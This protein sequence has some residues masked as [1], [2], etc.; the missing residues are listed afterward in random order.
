MNKSHGSDSLGGG[1]RI[2][3]EKKAQD[4]ISR[5]F[6]IFISWPGW[7]LHKCTYFI[8][9]PLGIYFPRLTEV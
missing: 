9:I 2:M 4:E 8:K 7:W 3:I 5:I 6:G 1:W